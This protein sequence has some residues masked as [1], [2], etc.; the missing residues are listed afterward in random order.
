[1][2]LFIIKLQGKNIMCSIHG[3][4]RVFLFLSELW[5]PLCEI[6]IFK[7]NSLKNL[8]IVKNWGENTYYADYGILDIK[9]RW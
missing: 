1:M 5:V 9:S 4:L 2:R 7:N 8:N 3:V 6:I